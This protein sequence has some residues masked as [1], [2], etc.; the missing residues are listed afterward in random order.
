MEFKEKARA[1][2][3][4]S[5]RC[6]RRRIFDRMGSSGMETMTNATSFVKQHWLLLSAVV[7]CPCH[8]PITLS[9]IAALA[10][11]TTVGALLRGEQRLWIEAGLAGIL[12]VYMLGA[13]SFWVWHSNT[14]ARQA[15]EECEG[16]LEPQ[17]EMRSVESELLQEAEGLGGKSG[18]LSRIPLA[19]APQ[20]ERIAAP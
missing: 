3:H 10:G 13:I 19:D 20:A 9:L 11:G 16:C 15:S 2:P 17:S 14:K 18:S 5:R 8:L 6:A 1:V 12:S 4:G 7:L